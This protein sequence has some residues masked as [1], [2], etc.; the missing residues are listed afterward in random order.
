MTDHSRPVTL[1]DLDNEGKLLWVYCNEC[2]RERDVP[3]LSLGL[4]PETPVPQLGNRL[5]CSQC[6]SRKISAKPEL[7]P[8]GIEA[9][10]AKHRE[11]GY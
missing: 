1:G 8:G 2:C 6:G 10:R 5:K 3:P 11:A 9:I 7:Y 4:P